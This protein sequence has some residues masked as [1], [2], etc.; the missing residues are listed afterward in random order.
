[1]EEIG[2]IRDFNLFDAVQIRK[3]TRFLSLFVRMVAFD[4]LKSFDFRF[5]NESRHQ[6]LQTRQ[7]RFLYSW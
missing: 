2:S 5:A 6:R 3:V 7:S 1:M 4:S